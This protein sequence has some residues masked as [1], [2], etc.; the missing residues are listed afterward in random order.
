MSSL[1]PLGRSRDPGA[2]LAPLG[3]PSCGHGPL[4]RRPAP[5]RRAVGDGREPGTFAPSPPVPGRPLPAPAACEPPPG[6]P[7]AGPSREL[8]PV[9][10]RPGPPGPDH[11]PRDLGPTGPRPARTPA[12]VHTSHR[13]GAT[14]SRA[15]AGAPPPRF[16]AAPP[17]M[18]HV[19][20]RR[21]AWVGSASRA[22]QVAAASDANRGTPTMATRLPPRFADRRATTRPSSHIGRPPDPA[23]AAARPPSTSARARRVLVGSPWRR[24]GAGTGRAGW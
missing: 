14:P 15:I 13:P 5:A 20:A 1:F 24:A 11:S 8:G 6:P 12:A 23:G 10:R 18:H 9:G 17:A 19:K 3:R 16:P 7:V 4:G 22:A 21:S 2:T